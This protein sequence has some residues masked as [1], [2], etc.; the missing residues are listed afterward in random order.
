[1]NK[2]R[3]AIAGMLF[4]ALAAVLM[5][6]LYSIKVNPGLNTLYNRFGV[7]MAPNM[8]TLVVF[9]WRGYDT[10]G[11]CFILVCGVLALSLLFGRGLVSEP[12]VKTRETHHQPDVKPT[13]VLSYFASSLILFAIAYGIYL[14]LGGH[15]TPGGG[16]QGG[17]LIASGVL[18]SLVV[19]GRRHLIP[20][21]HNF[22]LKLETTGLLIYLLLGLFGLIFSGYYLYNL[23]VNFYS[24][25]PSSIS[26]LFNYPDRVNAGILPYL[27]IAVMLKVSA[28][29]S[30]L[31]LVL[32]EVKSHD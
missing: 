25:V 17:S 11:E 4:A 6:S 18:L 9:D 13:L 21:D 7:E 19:Y 23:G 29:L 22:L 15:I 31:I 5:Y 3:M 28:G 8:V 26:S 20:I 10:L 12:E 32:L 24:I 30:T 14:T 2:N 1:V 27:N 16:F